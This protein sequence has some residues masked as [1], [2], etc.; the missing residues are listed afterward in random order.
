MGNQYLARTVEVY[1]LDMLYTQL[2]DRLLTFYSVCPVTAQNRSFVEGV[3][4]LP[5]DK[6][7]DQ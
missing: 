4:E 5:S 6:G 2:P 3:I 1:C 7:R